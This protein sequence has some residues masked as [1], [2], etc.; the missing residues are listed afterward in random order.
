MSTYELGL[1]VQIAINALMGMSAFVVLATGQLTLGNAGFMAIGAYGASYATVKLGLP[2][3]LGIPAGALAAAVVGLAV[4]F[5]ALR[6]RGIYLAMATFGFGLVIESFFLV[7]PPTGGARGYFGMP[8]IEISAVLLWS[9]LALVPVY[10]LYRSDAWLAFRAT[11]DDEYAADLTGLDTTR[12]KVASFTIGGA[13]AGLA[14]TLYAHW[15]VYIEPRSFDFLVSIFAVLFVV[16]G[17]RH[18][19]WGPLLGAAGLTLLP[20]LARP[21]QQWRPAFIGGLLILILVFRPGGLV[22]GRTRWLEPIRSLTGRA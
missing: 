4:G 5:P 17:G 6:L 22:G 15:F 16:L 18:S 2:L 21:L 3:W 11:D 12:L 1:L 14:G 9:S 19:F 8:G 13:L 7:F 20:E 10:L